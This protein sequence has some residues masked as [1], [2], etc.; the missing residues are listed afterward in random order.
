MLGNFRAKCVWGRP[1]TF[2]VRSFPESLSS[3]S[4]SRLA[5]SVSETLSLPSLFWKVTLTI[6]GI[7]VGAGV[8]V[9]VGEGEGVGVG[10]GAGVGVGLDPDVVTVTVVDALPADEL[11]LDEEAGM[12]C[13]QPESTRACMSGK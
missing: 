1:S 3:R 13:S 11:S 8:G 2:K 7:G 5:S 10:V 4:D 9:G 12:D 6:V